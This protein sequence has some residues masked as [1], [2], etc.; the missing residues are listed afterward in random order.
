M[1]PQSKVAVGMLDSRKEGSHNNDQQK[2]NIPSNDLNWIGN[3]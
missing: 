1:P 3:I 2:A